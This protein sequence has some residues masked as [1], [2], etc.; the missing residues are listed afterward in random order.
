MASAEPLPSPCRLHALLVVFQTGKLIENVARG[1]SGCSQYL[2]YLKVCDQ[3]GAHHHF[4]LV[5]LVR[6]VPGP[7][8][9]QR[10]GIEV[11]HFVVWGGWVYI[12]IYISHVYV[13]HRHMCVNPSVE[14]KGGHQ[15]SCS[16]TS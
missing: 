1:W 5:V 14:A 3:K 11:L 9:S 4:Q 7:I 13:L 2:S 16:I 10:E 6:S 12:Y 15:V 8:Q